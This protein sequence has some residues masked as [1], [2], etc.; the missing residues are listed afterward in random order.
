M[1]K[2]CDCCGKVI[3]TGS[4]YISVTFMGVKNMEKLFGTSELDF[5]S[6]ECLVKFWSKQ[7]VKQN[8]RARCSYNK[9]IRYL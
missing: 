5:C 7:E 9:N 4:E 6:F 3:P 1:S 2:R 8:A